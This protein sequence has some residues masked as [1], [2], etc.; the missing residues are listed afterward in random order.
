[1]LPNQNR[2]RS[3]VAV[4]A[5]TKTRIRACDNGDSAVQTGKF[6]STRKYYFDFKLMFSEDLAQALWRSIFKTEYF[7]V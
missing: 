4:V 3:E 1:M 6:S 5:L 2:P 7:K